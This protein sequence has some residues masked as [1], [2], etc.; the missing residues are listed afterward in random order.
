[1]LI[2]VDLM[3]R[4]T[5]ISSRVEEDYHS[6][7]DDILLVSVYTMRNVTVRGM[8]IPKALFTKEIHA[9]DDYKEYETMFVNVF[10]LINQPWP[11]VSTQGTHKSTPRAHMKPTLTSASP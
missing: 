6:I 1:M 5:S 7:K 10:V 3:K 11:V 9:I 2:I 8:L 4:F